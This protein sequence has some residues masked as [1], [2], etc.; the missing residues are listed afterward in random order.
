M[1]G[2]GKLTKII[3]KSGWQDHMKASFN[4]FLDVPKEK[5]QRFWSDG[6]IQVWIV[7]KK[8]D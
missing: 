3:D 2:L 6:L 5:D 4:Y 1:I 8:V 7:L